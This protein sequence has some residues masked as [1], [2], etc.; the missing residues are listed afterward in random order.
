MAGAFKIAI[1]LA[2][3]PSQKGINLWVLFVIEE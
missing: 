3:T 2:R 1:E